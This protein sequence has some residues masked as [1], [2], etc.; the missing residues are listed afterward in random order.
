[1]KKVHVF[2]LEGSTHI[3][4]VELPHLNRTTIKKPMVADLMRYPELYTFYEQ[5]MYAWE[6][7][8][9]LTESIYPSGSG[10]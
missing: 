6:R 8:I 10:A 1:M 4:G 2:K 3:A 5:D 9:P 7:A